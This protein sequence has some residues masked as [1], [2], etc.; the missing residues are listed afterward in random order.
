[1]DLPIADRCGDGSFVTL[2]FAPGTT[3][4]ARRALLVRAKAGHELDQ[5]TR[6][7][8]PAVIR[9]ANQSFINP[10]PTPK[11]AKRQVTAL[12]DTS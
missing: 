4:T 12:A 7:A 5:G 9:L 3:P 6:H 11:T 8:G 2:L 1:M 10:K